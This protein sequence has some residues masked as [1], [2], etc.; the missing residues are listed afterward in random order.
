[1]S[2]RTLRIVLWG[3]LLVLGLVFVW[4]AP[5]V[6]AGDTDENRA[7]VEQMYADYREDSFSELPDLTV[8]EARSVAD[9][10]AATASPD[11]DVIWLDVRDARERRISGLP[12][13]IDQQT[14]VRNR[15]DWAD[16]PVVVYCTVGYRSGLSARELRRKGV[17]AW[18]LAGGILAWAHEGGRVLDG[19]TGEPTRRVHVYGWRWNLLPEGWKA[20]W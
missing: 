12:D 9:S 6:R 2:R 11:D 14:F 3:V 8:A 20:V 16:R 18:N 4:V 5:R 19:R 15:E 7:R 17:E 13:A 1:M 10:L